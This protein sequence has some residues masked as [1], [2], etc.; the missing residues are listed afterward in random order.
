MR[1]IIALFVVII[2]SLFTGISEGLADEENINH[3]LGS[4]VEYSGVEGGMVDD[5]WVYP[6]FIGEKAV[7]GESTSR[8]SADKIDQQWL[9][10]DMGR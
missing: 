9:I 3:L 10:L 4:S 7:D 6:D 2:G 1:K 5:D 8:W